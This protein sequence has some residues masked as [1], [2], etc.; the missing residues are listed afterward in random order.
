MTV[1]RKGA[2]FKTIYVGGDA[3]E[4]VAAMDAEV[5]AEKKRFDEVLLYRAPMPFSRRRLTA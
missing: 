5:C 1:G 3:S 4:A 2:K